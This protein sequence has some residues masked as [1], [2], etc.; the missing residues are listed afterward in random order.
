MKSPLLLLEMLGINSSSNDFLRARRTL[1]LVYLTIIASVIVLFSIL[2]ILQIQT[3]FS[4]RDL[5][6]DSQIVLTAAEAKAKVTSLRPGVSIDN[7]QY[8]L[9][10]QTIIYTIGLANGEEV[11]FNLFTG[12]M[13]FGYLKHKDTFLT[14]ITDEI[15]DLIW[16]IGLFVF[17]LSGLGSIF[18][19][20]VTLRPIAVNMKK[21]QQFVSDAAHEL[22]NPLA[23]L[24]VT[25]ESFLLSNKKT[26]DLSDV[27]VRD[28]LSEVERLIATSESLLAFEKH[29]QAKNIT[30]CSIENSLDRVRKRLSSLASKKSITI[31]TD[32][33][34]VGIPYSQ[35]DLE[36]ILYNLIHNAIKFS[37]EHSTITIG[38]NGK[39]LTVT[40]NGIGIPKEHL[41]HIF[42]R[43]YKV[44]QSRTFTESSNGL[45]LALVSEIVENHKGKI[46]VNSTPNKGTTFAIT[47]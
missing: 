39:M 16:F 5:P 6:T 14:L 12:D 24:Q 35:H 15:E 30:H 42:D 1:V 34:D 36:T 7:T 45:G 11:E 40:D 19:A 26:L 41:P 9:E 17:L 2:V 20:N 29:K 38:W 18:V 43:F 47:F 28:S 33:V 25:L 32:L 10:R 27:V 13:A 37:S 46:E 4:E 22:R 8:K 21:Q 23:A 44:D 3:K 31:E